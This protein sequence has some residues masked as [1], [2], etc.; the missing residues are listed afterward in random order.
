[1]LDDASGETEKKVPDMNGSS[2]YHIRTTFIMTLRPADAKHEENLPLPTNLKSWPFVRTTNAS[3]G[4]PSTA[5][6]LH[7]LLDTYY[8]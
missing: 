3:L 4:A 7:T 2:S 1:M 5:S 6:A 8:V